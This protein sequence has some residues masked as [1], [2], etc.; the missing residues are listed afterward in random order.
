[1][2]LLALPVFT[3]NDYV[4]DP[5]NKR[6]HS[7][8]FGVNFQ[9]GGFDLWILERLRYFEMGFYWYHIYYDRSLDHM[10]FNVK[11]DIQLTRTIYWEMEL[12]SRATDPARYNAAHDP[13]Y[14][15]ANQSL[16]T[17][18]NE[19]P[20][21]FSTDVFNGTGL[22]GERAR[23]NAV[24]NVGFFETAFIM[25][26]HDWEMRVGYRLEQRSILGGLNTVEVVNFYDNKVFFS[27]TLLR[28]DVGNISS[29]PSRFIL[30]R[31]RIR[32]SDIGRG[33]YS[34]VGP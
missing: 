18:E 19:R 27:L 8:I 5:I 16:Y 13:R 33:G 9:T 10:R 31:Q 29:R 22:A 4:Y 7:N 25:D 6:D 15:L 12:E 30:N 32:P 1:M 20:V 24:F 23:Q 14:S 28:F 11:M 26:L 3:T 21:N 17:P 34:A 2:Y